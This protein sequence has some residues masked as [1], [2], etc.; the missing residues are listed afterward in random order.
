[1]PLIREP[2]AES[3]SPDVSP[4]GKWIAYSYQDKNAT[5]K[6]GVAI[7]AFEG[8]SPTRRVDVPKGLFRWAPDGRSLLYIKY[9]GD[10][11]NIWSQPIAGGA[12]RQITHFKSDLIFSFG[13]S[14]DGKRI[15]MSRGTMKE[16]VVLIHDLR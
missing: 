10:A 15:V 14:R 5:P 4:D 1:V 12:P 13:I 9:E 8:G 16:D 11:S 7:M 6:Q 3:F 2:R